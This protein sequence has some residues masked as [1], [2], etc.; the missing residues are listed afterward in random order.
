MYFVYFHIFKML[1]SH[2]LLFVIRKR[3]SLVKERAIAYEKVN[4]LTLNYLRFQ[5]E[6]YVLIVQRIPM[7]VKGNVCM[8]RNVASAC[9][10]ANSLS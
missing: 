7:D 5:I 2:L 3:V 8:P 1:F 9:E 10:R 6:L 4:F